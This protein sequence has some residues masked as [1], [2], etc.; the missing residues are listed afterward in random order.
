MEKGAWER[1]IGNIG[2]GALA[3]LRNRL[4]EV[5]FDIQT[6][7]ICEY[8]KG[9]NHAVRLFTGYSYN[10]FY[11]WDLYFDNIYLSYYGIYKYNRKNAE[12]FLDNQLECG[13]VARTLKEPRQRQ[14]FKPFLAQVCL[15]GSHQSGSFAWLYGKYYTALQKYLDYWFW[16]CDFDKNGLAVWDSADHSGMDNQDLRAGKYG[17]MEMEGVDLNCY[18]HR[19]L[20]AMAVISENLGLPDNAEQYR[21]HAG[22]LAERINDTLWDEEDAFYYDRNERKSAFAPYQSIAGFTPLWAGIAPKGRAAKIVKE[23]LTNPKEF[24]LPYPIATWR[25]DQ[26]GYYQQT[27]GDEC[28]WMG[29]VWAPT[30]YMVFQG[31][32]KYG[33]NDIARELAYQ[34]FDMVLSEETTREY[35]NGET[36]VGQGLNPFWGWSALA[37]F[38]PLEY[39]TGYDPTDMN[40]HEL[41]KLGCDYFGLSLDL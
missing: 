21:N 20:M 23:H 27:K 8:K 14:H 6:K 5:N 37:Y 3:R 2:E 38:M 18:L 4:R 41:I 34:T 1:F 32:R 15:M 25:R 10:E 39:E 35:Y 19:E 13:F 24:W 17:A 28:N 29:A 36:G 31:L 30:N 12:A 22:A 40:R 11:D 26:P 16:F 7:G 33:Y 9:N